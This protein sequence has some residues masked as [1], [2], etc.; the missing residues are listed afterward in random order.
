VLSDVANKANKLKIQAAIGAYK[1][2]AVDHGE[3]VP[4]NF[5]K[6]TLEGFGINKNKFFYE[7]K[8]HK[9]S[10]IEDGVASRENSSTSV[11][12][13]GNQDS[14]DKD[15]TLPNDSGDNNAER[16]KGGRP[17]GSSNDEKEQRQ[18]RKEKAIS[19]AVQH[20]KML[21]KDPAIQFIYSRH[22]VGGES[23]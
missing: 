21:V 1:E 10:N 3:Q 20:L 8:K 9:A 12:S 5:V 14:I 15:I 17:W 7:L 13:S 19:W 22:R 2:M 6:G 4:R 18:E 23:A 16:N 11:Q